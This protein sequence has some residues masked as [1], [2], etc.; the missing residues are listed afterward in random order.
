MAKST[1]PAPD[2]QSDLPPPIPPGTRCARCME[3]L[4]DRYDLAG[5]GTVLFAVCPPCG[6]RLFN[7]TTAR[8][9]LEDLA[10]Q[11]LRLAE[12]PVGGRA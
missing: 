4:G 2:Q 6:D 8:L 12:A 11:F 3:R 5:M 10:A 9:A 7:D 1:S